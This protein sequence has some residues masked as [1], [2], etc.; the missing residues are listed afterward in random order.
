MPTSTRK[1]P[2][3]DRI[4]RP[5]RWAEY[6]ALGPLLRRTREQLLP[7][8]LAC[9][10]ALVLG[11]GDGRFLATLL[12]RSP[13]LQAVAVDTS[14]AMLALLCRRC[15][16][17]ANRLTALHASATELPPTLDLGEFDLV[18]THFFLDCLTQPQLDVLAARLAKGIAPR[19]LW[20]LSD[21]AIPPRQPW[22]TLA[23]IYIRLLYLAFGL[24][25]GLR[26]RVLPNPQAA[27]LAAGFRQIHRSERLGG[28]LYS[29]LW[30]STS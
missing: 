18:V 9:R 21:F 30:Q 5:Y 16:F 17:A 11:D 19:A 8:V 14:G 4:A 28:L 15:A 24:L 25:T 26:V 13:R 2:N 20:L 6:L 23:S 22:R 10:K 7:N 27:L 1:Q 12:R 3:F 29:E